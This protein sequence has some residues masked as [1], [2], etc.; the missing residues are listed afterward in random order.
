M[1]TT[2]RGVSNFTTTTTSDI[3]MLRDFALKMDAVWFSE[4]F[5]SYHNTTRRHN[6][7]YFDLKDATMIPEYE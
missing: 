6:P 3:I 1:G 7:K 5:I 2:V 4:T